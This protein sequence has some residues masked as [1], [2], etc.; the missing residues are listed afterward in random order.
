MSPSLDTTSCSFLMNKSELSISHVSIVFKTVAMV[1][2]GV[3]V[4]IFSVSSFTASSD[5]A[6]FYEDW[7]TPEFIFEAVIIGPI[8]E[9]FVVMMLMP[10]ASRVSF[11]R[12]A[13]CGGVMGT[14]H[15]SIMGWGAAGSYLV[16]FLNGWIYSCWRARL[17]WQLGYFMAALSHSL[18]NLVICLLPT[19]FWMRII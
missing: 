10:Q 15:C 9:T 3:V 6:Y 18:H 19:S 8:L 13:I 14:L 5:S 12:A 1:G 4:S 16:F 2:L 11:G 17:N 7:G